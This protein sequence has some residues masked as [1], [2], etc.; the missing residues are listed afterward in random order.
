MEKSTKKHEMYRLIN[1]RAQFRSNFSIEHGSLDIETD[2]QF[3]DN[4]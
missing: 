3:F 4:F 1:E 2:I